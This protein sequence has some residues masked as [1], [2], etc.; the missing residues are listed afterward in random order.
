MEKITLELST[1]EGIHLRDV[2]TR[3]VADLVRAL[4]GD[5]PVAI[6]LQEVVA[7]LDRQLPF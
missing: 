7:Q 4:G 6:S 5:Y 2:V 3:D 1:V